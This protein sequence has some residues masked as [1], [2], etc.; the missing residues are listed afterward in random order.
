MLANNLNCPYN[1]SEIVRIAE[2]LNDIKEGDILANS[3]ENLY[4]Y[5]KHGIDVKVI[6]D[7]IISLGIDVVNKPKGRMSFIKDVLDVKRTTTCNGL[8]PYVVVN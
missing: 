4:L 2:W 7:E 6:E 5:V 1:G 3:K 8:K